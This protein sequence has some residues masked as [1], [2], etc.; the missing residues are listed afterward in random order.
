MVTNRTGKCSHLRSVNS[1]VALLWLCWNLLEWLAHICWVWVNEEWRPAV[2]I[3]RRWWRPWFVSS[4]VRVPRVERRWAGEWTPR[5]Y[6]AFPGSVW[7][8]WA[9]GRAQGR[10]WWLADLRHR[11]WT[12][13]NRDLILTYIKQQAI[14]RAAA[15]TYRGALS[16]QATWACWLYSRWS[17]WAFRA[18]AL[19]VWGWHC[20]LAFCT[21]SLRKT[22]DNEW[23]FSI[24]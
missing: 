3:G 4:W 8:F 20:A 14:K 16:Q 17:S 19:G 10:S 7:A 18:S 21:S 24:N 11:T 9:V 22:K 13:L 1:P 12:R 2:G 5:P 15:E 6:W 23:S